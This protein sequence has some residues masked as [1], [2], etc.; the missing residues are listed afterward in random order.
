MANDSHPMYKII[1]SDSWFNQMTFLSL[2]LAKE[3]A[4]LAAKDSCSA[5][6]V[7]AFVDRDTFRV[8]YTP[9][10]CKSGQAIR[11]QIYKS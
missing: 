7:L 5:V 1:S 2:A 6:D 10:G 9:K 11:T 3:K 4:D 8:V